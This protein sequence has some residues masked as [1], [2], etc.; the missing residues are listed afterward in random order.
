MDGQTATQQGSFMAWRRVEYYLYYLASYVVDYKTETPK[1][2][3]GNDCDK[4]YEAASRSKKAASAQ[5]KEVVAA[6]S[7]KAHY[8]IVASN[9]IIH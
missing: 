9:P 5:T 6:H 7:T 4:Y 2:L 3:R 8:R 1:R